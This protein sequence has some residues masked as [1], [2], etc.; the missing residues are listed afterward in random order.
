M[1]LLF[2][3][4]LL[5]DLIIRSLEERE[6]EPCVLLGEEVVTYGDIR[7]QTSQL[8]QAQR[9]HGVGQGGHG[10]G[11]GTHIAVLSKNRPEVITNMAASLINGCIVTPLHPMGQLGDHDYAVTDA[12]VECLVFDPE[13]FSQRA[14][15]L[16]TLHPDLLLLGLGPNDVGEDYLALAATFEPQPL[17]GPD[18]EPEDL[19]SIIY[20]GGTTGNPKGVLMSHRVWAAMT[21]I[22][23]AEWELPTE[24]RML[25][26]T[27]LSHAALSLL[28]PV[29][30][31]GG[32]FHVMD[33][34]DPDEFYDVIEQNRIHVVGG[35][36]LLRGV[37]HEPGQTGRR[38]RSMGPDLFPVL[39]P[40]RSPDGHRPHE[41][42][43]ARPGQARATVIVWQTGALDARGPA[44]RPGQTGRPRRIGR[45]L[46]PRSTGHARL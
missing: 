16:K 4:P 39:R 13:H 8:I 28:G 33:G 29:L 6:D 20:T 9:R 21:W 14:A 32:A 18:I 1:P 22:Q 11:P 44:R 5:P 46:H 23:M 24:L 40:D 30:L 38:H 15:E 36:D 26:A 45:D 7:R 35:D 34:F 37:T 17:T 31:N 10:V 41:K 42:G 43:R 12:E 19:C 3:Q 27:P 2:D 25:V